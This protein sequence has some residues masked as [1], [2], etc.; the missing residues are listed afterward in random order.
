MGERAL[1][2]SRGKGTKTIGFNRE[3]IKI[4]EAGI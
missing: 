1:L 3:K 4:Q 2:R